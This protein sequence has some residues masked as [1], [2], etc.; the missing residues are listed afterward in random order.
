MNFNK[1]LLAALIFPA[2][3]FGAAHATTSLPT[4]KAVGHLPVMT[5]IGTM[6]DSLELGN[7]IT[8][9]ASDFEFD[10]DDLDIEGIHSYVWQLND[11]DTSNATLS[12]PLNLTA[13]SDIGKKLTLL[14]I[15]K[16]ITGYPKEGKPLKIVFGV[17]T[18]KPTWEGNFTRPTM[19]L[20]TWQQA[21]DFC[22]GLTPA[23]RLPTTKQL[24]DM[25]LKNTS[26]TA[27]G[28]KSKDMCTKHGWP[29]GHTSTCGG[30]SDYWTSNPAGSGYHYIVTM[31]SGNSYSNADRVAS[32]VTC[33]F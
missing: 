2:Q 5:F 1:D 28:Q 30:V 14:V 26:A 4:P 10:D 23:A 33:V 15:P 18:D 9:T 8:F 32:Q 20:W 22:K 29:I 25:Y 17:I 19:Q 13:T 3:V 16:T 31:A 11:V 21:D 12:Y 27:I 6:P 24:Q 7:T